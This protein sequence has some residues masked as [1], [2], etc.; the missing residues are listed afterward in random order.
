[1]NEIKPHIE[2][3]IQHHGS[4][5]K[6]AEVMGCSQQQISYLLKAK[7]ITAE[8]AMRL[9]D[10]TLGAVSKHELRPDIFGPVNAEQ[11]ARA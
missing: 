4:Q 11:G 6:L 2:R 7:G 9:H 8:M 3:A 1:M 10:A 5:A